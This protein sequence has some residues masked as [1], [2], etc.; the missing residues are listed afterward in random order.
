MR[1]LNRLVFI[2]SA[3]IPYSEVMVNGNVHLI[4]TQG[5]GKSTLLRAIL[6]FYNA[7]TLKLGIPREKKSYSEYYFPYQNSYVIYEVARETGPYC[8][9]TFKSHGKVCYRFI[10]VGY[11]K[12]YFISEQGLAFQRWE[13][14]RR[15]LDIDKIFYSRKVENYG[16]YRD[17]LYGNIEGSRK[18]FSRYALLQSKQYQNIP[19]TIQNV[20]LNSKLDAEFIK[21]TIIMSLN[22]EDVNID[23]E[24]YA[25][26]LRNFEGQLSDIY[27]YKQPT[28]QRLAENIVKYHLGI[29]HRQ[30]DKGRLALNLVWAS[31][32][33]QRRLPKIQENASKAMLEREALKE[34]KENAEKKLRDKLIK[35]QASISVFESDLKRAKEKAEYYTKLNIQKIVERVSRRKDHDAHFRT[36]ERNLELLNQKAGELSQKYESLLLN[37]EKENSGYVQERV[38]EKF[39]LKAAYSEEQKLLRISL[40]KHITA[41]REANSNAQQEA[42]F[43]LEQQKELANSYRLRKESL[44]H[45]RFFEEEL[46]QVQSELFELQLSIDKAG[47]NSE[48]NK[49][50]LQTLEKQWQLEESGT[51][52]EFASK[53]ERCKK[54]LDSLQ[55]DLDTVNL[56]LLNSKNALYGWLNENRNGWEEDIG[57]VIDDDVL[58]NKT[59]DPRIIDAISSFYGISI[60]LD[61]LPVK[62][63]SLSEI[64]MEQ[65]V[66]SLA[67][68]STKKE[69]EQFNVQEIDAL[70]KLKKKYQPQLR[71]CKEALD[72]Q[73]YLI[74]RDRNQLIVKELY[75]KDLRIKSNEEKQKALDEIETLIIEANQSVLKA[76]E[77]AQEL[78]DN[79]AKQI[80]AKEKVIEKKITSLE[81][82]EKIRL[83]DLELDIQNFKNNIEERKNRILKTR[84]EEFA[85]RGVDTNQIQ[86]MEREL[87]QLKEE[88][89]F[90]EASRDLVVEYNKDKRELL[91]KVDDFKT[92]K[93]LLEQQ[94]VT[95]EQKYSNQMA[96]FDQG[97]EFIESELSNLNKQIDQLTDDQSVFVAFKLTSTWHNIEEA[98][99]EE[100]E[101]F[102]TDK[103]C[104]VLIE[105]LTHCDHEILKYWDQLKDT[106]NKFLG[107]FSVN[108][109]FSFKTNLTFN[110]EY[111]RFADQMDEFI[112]NSK[113]EEYE[114]RV[115]ER[116]A[117]II[118]SVGKETST[119]MSKSGE[120]QNV[121]RDINRDFE[122]KNFVT[123]IQKIELRLDESANP[124]VQILLLIK[125]YS[126]EHSSTLGSTNLFSSVDQ[127]TQN[128]KAIDLLKQLSKAMS[129]YKE[130]VIAL[131]DTFELKFRIEENQN[132]S[133][134]VEKLSSV[135][136]EGTDVL[137]KAMINIMLLNVF[138]EGASK[139]FK[140]FRLHCMM[141]EIGKLHP[142]NVKGILQ[143]ANDR[144]IN[145]INGSPTETNAL[146][147]KHIY[148]LEKDKQRNTRIKRILTHYS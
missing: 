2:N 124:I 17:I 45:Q 85:G 60:R 13:E 79:V 41:I 61:D 31:G 84:D 55:S 120:I 112:N 56:K 94:Y 77:M 16:E 98:F 136:S 131:S 129:D 92:N 28:I 147:Y 97:I 67:I 48:Y 127:D 1:Y 113:I 46:S 115:N 43:H 142:V 137:V 3:T 140:E 49:N 110:E 27:Q 5:V 101:A 109:I 36:I 111:A 126:D 4:G 40:T 25:H 58:F 90:I 145:L 68:E 133:G 39:E 33:I 105:E 42:S 99:K 51:K 141:D 72:E 20:L 108:N 52:N 146:D 88:L 53:V 116:F 125:Q 29:K 82:D 138:K 75:Q 62:V 103:S 139:K 96:L 135:G 74:E 21:Q 10:D 130:N 44:R 81:N 118:L 122:S 64:E 9:M 121:I 86:V 132:D 100:K 117:T 143:F 35:L 8:I 71:Q 19:R 70:D 123:A 66:T 114:K 148:R 6:F 107:Y 78:A 91:N 14:C 12:K 50:K 80:K 22:E 11:D 134:W 30:K 32:N 63:K 69:L 83:Q 73:Q 95:E 26:H 37:L 23:L 65:N 7:D 34:K 24:K 54:Q 106:A 128:R 87:Q 102:K 57:K 47:N 76:Q 38:N 18:E 119:L 104:K 59:L 89:K 144:N 15:A 93:S